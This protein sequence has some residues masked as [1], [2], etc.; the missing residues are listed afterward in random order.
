LVYFIKAK[1]TEAKCLKIGWKFEFVNKLGGKRVGQLLLS[2]RQKIDVYAGINLS[3]D[4]KNSKVNGSVVLDSGIANYILEVDNTNE[5]LKYYLEKLEPI[6]EFAIHQN[7]YFAC[8]AIN[9]R[10]EKDKW[11]S[12]RPLSVY[13][14]WNLENNILKGELIM[15]KPLEIKANVIGENIKSILNQLKIDASNFDE[16][17]KY[18]DPNINFI[19]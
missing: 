10:V 13:V 4:K 16:L 19:E 6:E 3:E 7:I 14:N 11:D 12:N 9:Y 8:K 15:D 18:L 1:R 17:K 5:D 2:N